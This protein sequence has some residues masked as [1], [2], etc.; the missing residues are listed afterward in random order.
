V[1]RDYHVFLLL[2]TALLAGIGKGPITMK[3]R[4]IS[5]TTL[6]YILIFSMF[7]TLDACKSRKPQQQEIPEP[8]SS[9]L[10]REALP[11]VDDTLSVM[12]QPLTFPR[13]F[14]LADQPFASQH[15]VLVGA[16]G[17]ETGEYFQSPTYDVMITELRRNNSSYYKRIDV[18]RH[19]DARGDSLVVS[20]KDTILFTVGNAEY[21]F[22]RVVG[23][24][25]VVTQTTGPGPEGLLAYNIVTGRKTCELLTHDMES[26]D[27]FF[28]RSWQPIDSAATVKNCPELRE[29]QNQG[30]SGQFERLYVGDIRTGE[31]KWLTEVRCIP[32]Q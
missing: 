18:L 19:I 4:M 10:V 21:Y 2:N 30:L 22:N 15:Y 5:H 29:W 31:V 9:S 32:T 14:V 26:W 24:Y 11:S 16:A 17:K 12:Y 27:G 7:L 28:V 8:D 13:I 1:P 6:H 25:L 23:E 20:E 3:A